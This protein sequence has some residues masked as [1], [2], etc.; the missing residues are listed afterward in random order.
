MKNIFFFL[1]FNTIKAVS[2]DKTRFIVFEGTT[3][4][5]LSSC[6]KRM[7][8]FYKNKNIKMSY[9]SFPYKETETGKRIIKIQKEIEKGLKEK[10]M[11]L[12]ELLIKNLNEVSKEAKRLLLLGRHVILERFY[13]S[14]LIYKK[15]LFNHNKELSFLYSTIMIQ[16]PD[17]IF[18]FKA[19]PE[20][21]KKR[22]KKKA[23]Y[24][25]KSNYYE[26]Y[27]EQTD[28]PVV[29]V[30][31]SKTEEEVFDFVMEDVSCL[32]EQDFEE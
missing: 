1:F 9:L 27:A 30:D 5:G 31:V 14:V 32:L 12:M 21:I 10:E 4:V 19:K 24:F 8:Y 17:L 26:R 22:R 3:E 20:I 18:L 25:D 16:K 7:E 6:I 11:F 13:V 29:F 2:Y 28:D 15:K 23:F